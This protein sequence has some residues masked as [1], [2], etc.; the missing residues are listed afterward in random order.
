MSD[1]EIVV[2]RTSIV[3]RSSE[4]RDTQDLA[5]VP[6]SDVRDLE[7]VL[8][9]IWT[10]VVARNGVRVKITSEQLGVVVLDSRGRPLYEVLWADDQRSSDDA[11]WCNKKFPADWWTERIG[12][13]PET[14]HGIT[15]LSWLHRS[16]PGVWEKIVR[17]CGI[18]DH[19]RSMC[20]G[21][22]DDRFA[23]SSS[24]MARMGWGTPTHADPDVLALVDKDRDW[25]SVV[26][27]IVPAGTVLGSRDGVAIV[28]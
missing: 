28:M 10:D 18:D 23:V 8:A 11:A 5:E 1:L 6:C 27:P 16:E 25:S 17:V 24:T 4:P 22:S 3:L 13:I 2:G 7:S 12:E 19:A 14:R 20:L 15:K 9:T 21:G 26:P